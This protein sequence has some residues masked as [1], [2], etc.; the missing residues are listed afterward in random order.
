MFEESTRDEIFKDPDTEAIL[1]TPQ[2][3][4]EILIFLART[5]GTAATIRHLQYGLETLSKS[6]EISDPDTAAKY[7]LAADELET[8]YQ[9]IKN[10]IKI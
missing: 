10:E 7:R 9:K 4:T 6:W 3:S 1:R 8:A 5:E 2:S